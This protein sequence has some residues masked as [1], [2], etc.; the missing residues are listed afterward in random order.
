MTRTLKLPDTTGGDVFAAPDTGFAQIAVGAGA[1]WA[2]NP[3]DTISRIDAETGDLVETVDAAASTIAAGKEGVWFVPLERPSVARIDPRTNRVA[4]T[5]LIGANS[6]SAIAVGAGSVWATAETEG[7]VHR[8][9]PGRRQLTRTIDVGVGV[10]YIAF[11]EGAV[12][13]ANYLDGT[14]SRIDPRTNEVTAQESIGVP[15][16]IAAGE[17]SAWVSVAGA[18]SEGELPAFACGEVASGGRRPDVLIASDLPLRGPQSAAPRAMARRHPAR[19]RAAR[20]RG[21]GPLG[22][23]CVV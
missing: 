11:G 6:L 12:W 14:V 8:I 22:R 21:G 7:V 5:I 15:Q 3:D 9:V 18:P 1:V 10:S 23:I 17:G 4:E 20:L 19:G 13:A 2:R 16:A